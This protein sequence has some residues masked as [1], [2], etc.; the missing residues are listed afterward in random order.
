MIRKDHSAKNA[1][2]NLYLKKYALDKDN[3]FRIPRLK[4][5]LEAYINRLLRAIDEAFDEGN[6]VKYTG[7]EV[8]WPTRTDKEGIND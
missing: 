2:K 6:V 4:L 1:I 7:H 3:E 5:D 8:K